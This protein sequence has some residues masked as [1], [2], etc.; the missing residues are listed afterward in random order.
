MAAARD[1]ARTPSGVSSV[2]SICHVYIIHGLQ[3]VYKFS[4]LIPL[5]PKK[6]VE[7]LNLLK[8]CRFMTLG[9]QIID[10]QEKFVSQSIWQEKW[11]EKL[12]FGRK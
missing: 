1:R 8:V 6:V 2:T 11:R 4:S 5:Q 9:R 7:I 12:A 10:S 3:I